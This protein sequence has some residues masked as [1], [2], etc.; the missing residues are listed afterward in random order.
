MKVLAELFLRQPW[1]FSVDD[2]M[3]LKIDGLKLGIRMI[4]SCQFYLL[5][6]EC[7]IIDMTITS[8]CRNILTNTVVRHH[9]NIISH[10]DWYKPLL[11]EGQYLPANKS[12]SPTS[13]FCKV[14]K[15]I[16]ITKVMP[17]L[18]TSD[19]T[20]YPGLSGSG[21][22]R[23]GC[24]TKLQ[25]KRFL[26]IT[27]TCNIEGWW[28]PLSESD[29]TNF[30]INFHSPHLSVVSV[31]I[32]RSILNILCMWPPHYVLYSTREFTLCYTHTPHRQYK[33]TQWIHWSTLQVT[34]TCSN[35]LT[36]MYG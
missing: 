31:Y 9:F 21:L 28:Q 33:T 19:L 29:V 5:A 27:L 6:I 26:S 16:I 3:H 7:H 12:S 8:A 15:N 1:R 32:L 34:A 24:N 13:T 10:V 23:S 35:M 25:S 11:T 14:N 2:L 30:L 36:A 4:S 22:I 20:L 17:R 18:H